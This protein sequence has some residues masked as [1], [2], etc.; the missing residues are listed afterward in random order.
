MAS[1]QFLYLNLKPILSL[2]LHLMDDPTSILYQQGLFNM[3]LPNSLVSCKFWQWFFFLFFFFL[4]AN[5]FFKAFLDAPSHL[6]KRTC[7]PVRPSVRPSRVIFLGGAFCAVY[8]AFF[9]VTFLCPLSA[10]VLCCFPQSPLLASRSWTQRIRNHFL[11][12]VCQSDEIVFQ[13]VND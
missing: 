10:P 1:R 3:V 7:P 13:G 9:Y 4:M 12:P 11:T 5:F 6:Y 8:P 2:F